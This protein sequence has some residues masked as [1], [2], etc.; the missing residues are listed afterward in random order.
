MDRVITIDSMF[1]KEWRIEYE[2]N[3]SFS[4]ADEMDAQRKVTSGK[5]SPYHSEIVAVGSGNKIVQLDIRT[6]KYATIK[7]T[8]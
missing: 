3:A 6:K 4:M 2:Q 7:T 5:W 1:I 8:I